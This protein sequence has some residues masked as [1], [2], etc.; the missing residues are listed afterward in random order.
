MCWN[1]SAALTGGLAGAVLAIISRLLEWILFRPRLTIIFTEEV[2]ACAT[3]IFYEGNEPTQRWLRIKIK[4]AGRST[5]FSVAVSITQLTL[6]SEVQGGGTTTTK[7]EDE[8]F[9]VRLAHHDFEPFPLAPHAH[10]FLDVAHTEKG[11]PSRMF[12]EFRP[13]NLE[14]HRRRGLGSDPGTYGAKIFATADNAKFV[15]SVIRWSWD[16]T[17]F[18]SLRILPPSR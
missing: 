18:L 13:N 15:R 5:A 1:W 4:N 3:N 9:A 17:S 8:V 12:Y 11:R 16:G 10:Q 14:R 2:E 6:T 7:V